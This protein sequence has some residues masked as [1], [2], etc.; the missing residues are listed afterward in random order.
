[1]KLSG[2]SVGLPL[3]KV[4]GIHLVSGKP[5]YTDDLA[6]KDCLIIKILRSPHAFAKIVD[7]NTVNAEKMPGVEIIF[8]HK[9]VP[10]NLYT[11]AGQSYPEPSVYDKYI[12]D[13]YV[14]YVGDEVAIVA[15]ESEEIALKA[16]KKIK[17][18]YEVFEPVLDVLKAEDSLSKLHFR[19]RVFMNMDKGFNPDKNIAGVYNFELGNVEESLKSCDVIAKGK[20]FTQAQGHGMMESYRAYSYIDQYGGL[21][22]VAS[23]QIPFHVRRDVAQALGLPINKVR[24]I[25]PR[26]GGGF[27][28]KQTVQIEFYPALV[29]YKTGKPSKLIYNRRETF[30]SS[31]TRHAMYIDVTIGSDKEGNIKAIDM[32][33]IS[34]TGAYGEHAITVLGA[35][36]Y[37]SLPLYNKVDAVRFTGKAIYTNRTPG[38]AFRGYGVTQGTFALESAINELAVKLEMDPLKLREKNMIRKGE[39]TPLFNMTTIGAGKDPI[40]MDSCELEYC[41][42]KGKELIDWDSK[43][44]NRE[45]S[46]TKIRGVGMAIAM[47]GSGIPGID[48]ATATIRLDDGGTFTL[49]TGAAD[50][51]TGSDTILKQIAA[52][53]LGV[54]NDSIS[55]FSADTELTPFDVGA[56]A[57]GTTYFSGNA[58]KE[59]ALKMRELVILEGARELGVEVKDV[60]YDGE[61]IELQ[62]GSKKISLFDL[63][64]KLIYKRPHVQLTAS[65]SFATVDLAP[66]FISGFAEVEVDLETGKVDLLEFVSVID[67]GTVINPKLARIQAEGGIVQGIGMALFEEVKETKKGKLITNSFMQYKIPCRM[68]INSITVEFADGFDATGPYGAKSIGEVVTNPVPPA[69]VDA[70]YNAVGIR[71]RELPIT[72]EKLKMLLLEKYQSKKNKQPIG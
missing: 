7:I 15:A 32:N 11:R 41:V 61:N 36:G 64:N 27:G 46:D 44:P 34:D 47:Q 23:T 20:Y 18:E 40:M 62:D 55:V 5:A 13:E 6:P 42:Q 57:S 24:V 35:A 1:M 2:N 58:V 51:G 52:E 29:T 31:T 65:G 48:T 30:E 26:I 50:I 54:S 60:V 3:S 25:K 43:F 21:V 33:A 59:A 69:I 68:D 17:V 28:G 14:R 67:C 63:S 38:G 71:I 72:P 70:V 12:L 16:I 39:T 10:K 19:D 45:I 56:Y 9:N 49:L 66:P 37:K 8:T 22:I 4:D 53:G